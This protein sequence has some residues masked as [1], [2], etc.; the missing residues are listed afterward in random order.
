MKKYAYKLR[1]FFDIKVNECA[2]S[3]KPEANF[4]EILHF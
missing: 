3:F 1:N 4:K 2:P